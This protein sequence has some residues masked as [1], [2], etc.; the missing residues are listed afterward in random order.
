MFSFSLLVPSVFPLITCLRRQFLRSMWPIQLAFLFCVTNRTFLSSLILCYNSSFFMRS[1]QLISPSF[2]AI[3]FQYI[4]GTFGLLSE[5]SKFQYH[6]KL[7]SKC[8]NAL[9]SSF[10]TNLL[11][12]KV[13]SFRLLFLTWQ[14]CIVF[15]AYF[16]YTYYIIHETKLCKID[17]EL[18]QVRL[19]NVIGMY[20]LS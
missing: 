14:T 3:A 13:C 19:Q 2:T 18:E 1:I 20:S 7:C 16:M 12:K 9:V 8:S 17:S 4:Q 10:K 11:V 6:T 5:V 15:Q